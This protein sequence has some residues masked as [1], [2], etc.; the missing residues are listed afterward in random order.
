MYMCMYTYICYQS[1]IRVGHGSVAAWSF[2]AA[3]PRCRAAA[4]RNDIKLLLLHSARGEVT[5]RWPIANI[6][7][8]AP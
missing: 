2:A 5:I 7:A 6:V 8:Y 1:Y 4:A 3:L